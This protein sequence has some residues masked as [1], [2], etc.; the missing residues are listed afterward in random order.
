VLEPSPPRTGRRRSWVIAV[1]VVSALGAGAVVWRRAPDE[2]ALS[3]RSRGKEPPTVTTATTL[4][5][6]STTTT[7]PEVTTTTAP[8]TTTS[9]RPVTSTTTRRPTP[10]TA[11]PSPTGSPTCTSSNPVARVPGPGVSVLRADGTLRQVID[12]TDTHDTINTPPV[13]APDGTRLATVRLSG[14]G[15]RVVV[16]DLDG[17]ETTVS[18]S[19][20]VFSKALAWTPDGK[21]LYVAYVGDAAPVRNRLRIA[22]PDG[23]GVSTVWEGPV[24]MDG[25]SSVAG[26][27]GGAVLFLS[28][29]GLMV[30][31]RDGSDPQPFGSVPTA[32]PG[33][34]WARAFSVSADHTRVATMAN[35]TLAM[36]DV[37]TGATVAAATATAG[38]S[39][40]EWSPDSRR[41]AFGGGVVLQDDGTVLRTGAADVAFTAAETAVTTWRNDGSADDGPIELVAADGSR[42]VVGHRAW[43]LAGGPALA[44]I[45]GPPGDTR[46]NGPPPGGAVVCLAGQPRALASFPNS[47]PAGMAWSP[48]G[49]HLTVVSAGLDY[50]R[51]SSTN[52]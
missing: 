15:G 6:P 47:Y 25:V 11:V 27:D 48:D 18:G 42:R 12:T 4:P 14:T 1:V 37:A 40:V 7:E 45:L 2:T 22:S 19:D 17:R 23:S 34:F 29:D 24:R 39:I 46:R 50:I 43:N 41:V 8:V 31:N 52:P 32:R 33:P 35:D 28:D 10:T 9:T 36:F 49:R 3:V 20:Q 26:L 16:V 5:L 13:W 30:V 21:I 38:N 44:A 51:P